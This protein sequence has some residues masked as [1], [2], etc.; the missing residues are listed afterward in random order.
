MIVL[1]L[2][3]RDASHASGFV[4]HGAEERKERGID[5]DAARLLRLRRRQLARAAIDARVDAHN[6]AVEIDVRPR[7]GV[8]VPS[9]RVEARR[10]REHASP[11]VRDVRARHK[12]G[13]LRGVQVNLRLA[14]ASVRSVDPL[15]WAVRANTEVRRF[16]PLASANIRVTTPHACVAVFHEIVPARTLPSSSSTRPSRSSRV[17]ARTSRAP[18]EGRTCVSNWLRSSATLAALARRARRASA[19]HTPRASRSW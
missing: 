17:I 4:V 2:D 19:S 10:D 9:S 8:H 1:R 12:G 16:A 11:A 14:R 15:R 7:E 13:E 3:G 18:R 5:R 6:A